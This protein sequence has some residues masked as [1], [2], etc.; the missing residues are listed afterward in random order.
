MHNVQCTSLY[1]RISGYYVPGARVP[2]LVHCPIIETYYTILPLC[3]IYTCVLFTHFQL[4]HATNGTLRLPALT[5]CTLNNPGH[6]QNVHPAPYCKLF[7]LIRDAHPDLV[8]P[9][10][11]MT[12]HNAYYATLPLNLRLLG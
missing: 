8:E 11:L 12:S 5:R 7:A 3:K 6:R 10:R 4:L 9:Q 2:L 1:T